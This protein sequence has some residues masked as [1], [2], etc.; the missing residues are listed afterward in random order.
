MAESPAALRTCQPE[1]RA[2]GW[3]QPTWLEYF[4][5]GPQTDLES[6]YVSL[7]CGNSTVSL[8]LVSAENV[9]PPAAFAGLSYLVFLSS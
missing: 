2:P 8:G 6:L 9:P 1:S 4:L 3:G 7:G 5:A